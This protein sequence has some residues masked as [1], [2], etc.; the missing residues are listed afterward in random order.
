VF[1]FRGS[2]E[3][4][5]RAADLRAARERASVEHSA[6]SAEDYLRSLDVRLEFFVG[7][8]A[9]LARC[10]E[11]CAKTNQFNLALSR[12]N[13]AD[14]A[15]RRDERA[16][17]VVAVRLADRLSDS[18]IVAVVVGRRAGSALHVDE[19]CVSCRALGRR[20]EDAMVSQALLLMAGTDRPD[21]IVFAVRRGPRNEPAR[22]W[23]SAYASASGD[24]GDSLEMPFA[25]IAAHPVST[26][27]AIDIVT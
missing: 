1:R 26:A 15:R 16:S 4:R 24:L 11:L 27:I 23:L 19:L 8:R 12:M 18:G 10:A 2:G 22:R 13:E 17:N 25:T 20:L 5:L 9:P 6:A 7:R 21:T 14:I 3:D